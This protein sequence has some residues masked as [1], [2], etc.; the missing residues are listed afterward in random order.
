M[1]GNQKQISSQ[2][3]GLVISI[4]IPQTLM[5]PIQA[6]KRNKATNEKKWFSIIPNLL[7]RDSEMEISYFLDVGTVLYYF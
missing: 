5:Q 6:R 7:I 3:L 4:I 2:S 1:A